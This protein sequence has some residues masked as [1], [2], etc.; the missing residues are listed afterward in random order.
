MLWRFGARELLEV[1]G[2]VAPGQTRTAVLLRPGEP[3]VPGLGEALA[4]VASEREGGAGPAAE[5]A[6]P[7]RHVRLEPGAQR[8][9]ERSLLG[10]ISEI[11]QRPSLDSPR[12]VMQVLIA[13]ATRRSSLS[14][15][16]HS[17]RPIVRPVFTVRAVATRRPLQYGRRKLIFSSRVVKLSPSSRVEAYAVPIAASATSQMIP[18]WSVPMGLACCGPASSSKVAFPVS[19]AIG[20]KPM[21]LPTGAPGPSPRTIALKRSI[22]LATKPPGRSRH[23]C[24]RANEDMRRARHRAHRAKMARR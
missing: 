10:P 15:T 24:A 3:G 13:R 9:A 14:V 12:R 5:A 18:P 16:S 20:R 19:I 7:R 11:H 2:L 23:R 6:Q 22:S 4:P 8:R 1:E 17:T 21:S